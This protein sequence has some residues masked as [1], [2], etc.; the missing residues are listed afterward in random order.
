MLVL[1]SAKRFCDRVQEGLAVDRAARAVLEELS[2]L[3]PGVAGLIGIN[4]NGGI[5]SMH[6]TPFM[7]TS[8]RPS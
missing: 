4:V 6:D 8:E 5:V 1:L 7:V 2:H 3:T